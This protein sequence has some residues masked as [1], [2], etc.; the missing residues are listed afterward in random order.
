[1]NDKRMGH[2][3]IGTASLKC[4][5][6][7]SNTA[8]VFFLSLRIFETNCS[9]FS[10]VKPSTLTIAGK[11]RWI[12]LVLWGREVTMILQFKHRSPLMIL[13]TSL[14]VPR[15][16]SSNPSRIIRHLLPKVSSIPFSLFSV[17]LQSPYKG[18][19]LYNDVF[20]CITRLYELQKYKEND[21]KSCEK[22]CLPS[23][24]QFS[25]KTL[26]CPCPGPSL[27]SIFCGHIRLCY[28]AY[29]P[30]CLDII[31]RF[32][33][34]QTIVENFVLYFRSIGWTAR[35]TWPKFYIS[36][37]IGQVI[38]HFISH[39]HS[40][41]RQIIP[42]SLGL[43]GL[44]IPIG[45]FFTFSNFRSVYRVV[46]INHVV[47]DP[48]RHFYLHRLLLCTVWVYPLCVKVRLHW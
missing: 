35:V 25:C 32:K 9:A 10:I 21:G 28:V 18:I 36:L 23:P 34:C 33:C 12:I 31:N 47:S 20:N 14:L 15:A 27:M 8:S 41:D 43:F 39:F 2:F 45:L 44:T 37:Y 13:R 1:M 26:S 22:F 11:Y 3:W 5:G 7:K 24:R 46:H 29:M 17:I 16:C 6:L 30:L 38:K 42:C 48:G 40:S 4:A 19:L